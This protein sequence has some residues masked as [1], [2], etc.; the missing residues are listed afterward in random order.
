MSA[1]GVLVSAE[2]DWVAVP[3]KTTKLVPNVIMAAVIHL[4]PALYIL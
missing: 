4:D 3:P 1:V 2:T